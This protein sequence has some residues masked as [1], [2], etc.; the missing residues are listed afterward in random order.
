MATYALVLA[1]FAS[2]SSDQ[3]RIHHSHHSLSSLVS[4]EEKRLVDGILRPGG[5]GDDR[6]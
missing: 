6:C 2:F 3:V 4:D 5:R 1:E